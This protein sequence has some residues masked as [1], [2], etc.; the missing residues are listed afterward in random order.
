MKHVE[1]ICSFTLQKRKKKRKE[2]KRREKKRK[3]RKSQ[4]EEHG[5]LHIAGA[6][7]FRLSH[8]FPVA[9]HIGIVFFMWMGVW[10]Q[11]VRKLPCPNIIFKEKKRE[12]KEISFIIKKR[13]RVQGFLG[14]H[15]HQEALNGT[16]PL[17]II[18]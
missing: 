12:V 18:S 4:G 9:R 1:G 5:T 16:P 10:V 13:H 8:V 6:I 3:E 17:F 11:E 2:K 14:H 7:F 15:T